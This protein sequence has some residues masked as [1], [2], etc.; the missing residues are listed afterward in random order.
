MMRNLILHIAFFAVFAN[1]AGAQIPFNTTSLDSFNTPNDDYITNVFMISSDEMILTGGRLDANGS[2]YPFLLPTVNIWK[3]DMDGNL[4]DY[5]EFSTYVGVPRN[6]VL[7]NVILYNVNN[8]FEQDSNLILLGNG[9]NKADSLPCIVYIKTDHNFKILTV[10]SFTITFPIHAWYGTRGYGMICKRHPDGG[11]YGSMSIVGYWNVPAYEYYFRLNADGTI[12]SNLVETISAFFDERTGKRIPNIEY[13]TSLKQYMSSDI[14]TQYYL[15]DSSMQLI[16]QDSTW[17]EANVDNNGVVSG[18]C[19]AYPGA[20]NFRPFF[21]GHIMAGG[22]CLSVTPNYGLGTAVYS[23]SIYIK[24][25]D[26]AF[27]LLKGVF[28]W[29]DSNSTNST[30]DITNFDF[31]N[32]DSI[33]FARCAE[34]PFTFGDTT[35]TYLESYTVFQTDGNF[36]VRWSKTF[37]FPKLVRIQS[38]KATSDGGCIL[39]GNVTRRPNDI[40]WAGADIFISKLTN[41]GEISSVKYIDKI[42][43][44]EITVFPNPG[45]DKIFIS[46]EATGRSFILYDAQ[47]KQVAHGSDQDLIQ[48][49]PV[50]DL[51]TGMYFYTITDKNTGAVKKGKWLK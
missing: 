28:V 48:G 4:K 38:I 43:M 37:P 35:D 14:S 50:A 25:Y 44:E 47:G 46:G 21:S 3:T 36:N 17:P 9:M 39:V 20:N 26:D 15:F 11:Y 30:P 42:T 13:S 6:T 45:T 23:S 31:I 29:G 2:N 18:L 51:T 40:N 34:I 27:H 33:F 41:K 32:A 10:N 1:N 24:K 12:R 19:Q 5:I 7:P 22:Y 8:V 16:K 49:I